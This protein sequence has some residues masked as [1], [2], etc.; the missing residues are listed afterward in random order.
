ML[1]FNVVYIIEIYIIGGAAA[2]RRLECLGFVFKMLFSLNKGCFF[3]IGGA[4]APRCL[5][6][7]GFVFKML[8]SIYICTHTHT[9]THTCS[10]HTKKGG[11]VLKRLLSRYMYMHI[12]YIIYILM[13]SPRYIYVYV[14]IKGSRLS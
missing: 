14:Y 10:S 9:H 5:E 7:L 8:F 6:C 3:I 2:P 11:I 13:Y 12:M 4:A 1:F